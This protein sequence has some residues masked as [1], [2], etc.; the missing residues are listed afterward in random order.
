MLYMDFSLNYAVIQS[1]L[2]SVLL[3]IPTWLIMNQIVV[4]SRD[5]QE[6][7]AHKVKSHDQLALIFPDDNGAVLDIE[8]KPAFRSTQNVLDF[9]KIK[10]HGSVSCG[11]RSR[12]I[13]PWVYWKE[14]KEC[15]FHTYLGLRSLTRI[16]SNLLQRCPQLGESTYQICSKSR[17]PILR[18]DWAKFRNNFF[19]FSS[20]RTLCIFSY[21]WWKQ[22]PIKL[23]LGTHIGLVKAHH[24]PNFGWN[25]IK[26]YKVI[27]DL[28]H[29]KGRRS[30]TPTG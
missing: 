17:Q 3:S 23:K 5:N 15:N 7:M 13:T 29:K 10:T 4:H 27:I 21:N 25:L 16:Q 9:L 14:D 20:F 11:P 28:L 12:R 22:T 24:H 8:P 19:I 6:I 1:F 18:Y 2:V 26:I 30:V